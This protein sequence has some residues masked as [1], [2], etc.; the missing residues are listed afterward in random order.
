MNG[1]RLLCCCCP[2]RHSSWIPLL[3]RSAGGLLVGLGRWASAVQ[4]RAAWLNTFLAK[5][6]ERIPRSD[7]LTQGQVFKVHTG[8]LGQR[9]STEDQ[10]EDG[11]Y[12]TG[13]LEITIRSEQD[14]EKAKPMLEQ[15]YEAS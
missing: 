6:P 14:F 3:Q 13:D 1:R 8:A 15:G 5:V 9:G 10:H 2:K 12:G 7:D 4:T 11:Y